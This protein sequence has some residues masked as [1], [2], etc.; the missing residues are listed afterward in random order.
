MPATT[1]AFSLPPSLLYLPTCLRALPPLSCCGGLSHLQLLGNV[2]ELRHGDIVASGRCIERQQN[3]ALALLTAGDRYQAVA[4]GLQSRK[5]WD[6][7]IAPSDT[8]HFRFGSTLRTPASTARNFP[9]SHS[10]NLKT[11]L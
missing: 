7:E 2:D 9:A 11:K 4:T 5:G 1:R 3:T 6:L 10:L 8:I